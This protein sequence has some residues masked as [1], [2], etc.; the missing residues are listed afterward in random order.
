[1]ELGIILPIWIDIIHVARVCKIKVTR[2]VLMDHFDHYD[3][4]VSLFSRR[5][6]HL[7]Q[8]V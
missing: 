7:A 1:M 3:L 4:G 2:E 5:F 6:V 8:K